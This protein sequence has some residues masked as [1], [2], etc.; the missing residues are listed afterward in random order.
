VAVTTVARTVIDFARTASFRDG[1]VVAD[2]AL[3][4]KKTCKEELSRMLANCRGWPGARRARRVVGFANGSAESALESIGRVVFDQHG[5]PPPQ[6]QAWVGGDD[7]VGRADFFWP[8]HNTVAEADGLMKYSENPRAK[9]AAQ[10]RRDNRLRDAG[11]EIVHFTWQEITRN[12][13]EVV[14]RLEAA[15]A[16]ADRQRDS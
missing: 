3:R 2:S 6:L 15:F 8:G 11:F 1:V 16:R 12:P 4:A 9:I 5:L 7:V 10:I 13:Q 14:D